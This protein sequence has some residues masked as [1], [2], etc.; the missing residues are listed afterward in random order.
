MPVCECCLEYT[1]RLNQIKTG[2]FSFVVCGDCIRD[3]EREES[4]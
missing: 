3:L 4:I 1:D 2:E